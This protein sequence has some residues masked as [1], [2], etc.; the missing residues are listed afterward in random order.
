MLRMGHY[1]GWRVLI[2]IHNK[3]TI[4]K[5]EEILGINIREYFDEEGPLASRSYGYS[6]FKKIGQF[7][8]IVSGDIKSQH[9]TQLLGHANPIITERVYRRKPENIKPFS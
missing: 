9:A 7:W 8:K 3:R 2:I 5:Y 4:K 6:I 1:V